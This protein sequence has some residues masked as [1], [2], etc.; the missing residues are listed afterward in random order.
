MSANSQTV[1]GEYEI[2]RNTKAC[3]QSKVKVEFM[4]K[5]LV[6]EDE[7][8]TRDMFRDCLEAEA[9]AKYSKR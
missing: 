5:I 1:V 2:L 6:I 3:H 9:A 8:R 4:S 7:A